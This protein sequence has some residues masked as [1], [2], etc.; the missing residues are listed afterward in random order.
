MDILDDVILGEEQTFPLTSNY[1]SHYFAPEFGLFLS[2]LIWI[3][4]P[5][6]RGLYYFE[7]GLLFCKMY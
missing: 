4:L 3:I 5:Y 1:I 2:L 6:L 7:L